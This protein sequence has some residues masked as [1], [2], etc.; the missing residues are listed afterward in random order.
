MGMKSPFKWAKHG[1]CGKMVSEIFPHMAKHVDKMAFVHSMYSESN[2]HSPALFMMNTGMARMGFPCVGSWVSYGLGSMNQ[3]LP[4]FVVLVAKP[5]NTEQVQ[6]ISG[7]LWSN[8][9]LPGEHAGVSFRS[10]GDPIL[11]INNPNGVTAGMRRRQLD[12]LAIVQAG[13]VHPR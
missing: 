9:F 3:N 4:T 8:G 13:L 1:G 10:S 2:N 5:T 7:K 6:A 12:G 11:Y